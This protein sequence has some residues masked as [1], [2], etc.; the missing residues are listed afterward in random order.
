M[1][2]KIT[3]WLIRYSHFDNILSLIDHNM[4]KLWLIGLNIH[5]LFIIAY[6]ILS[7]WLVG[8]EILTRLLSG[9]KILTLWLI[10]NNILTILFIGYKI[11][12]VLLI[13]YN[14]ITLWFILP[15][16][17]DTLTDILTRWVIGHNIHTVLLIDHTI[18]TTD[19]LNVT[20]IAS[21]ACV[22][23]SG[24]GNFFQMNIQGCKFNKYHNFEVFF[25]KKF[26]KIQIIISLWC[27]Y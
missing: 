13:G 3:L 7:H 18:L 14:I 15:Q 8:Q 1:T 20:S 4:L 16:C 5:T 11:L 19:F 12:S 10:G 9:H 25:G 21:S 22:K 17:T 24:L 6:K 26:K 27:I 2:Q 23:L